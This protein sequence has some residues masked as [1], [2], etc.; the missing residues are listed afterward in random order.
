MIDI[1]HLI[2]HEEL[3]IRELEKR[4]LDTSLASKAAQQYA[5]VN[6]L[7]R[8]LDDVRQ[9]KNEF[10]K[11]VVTLSGEEKQQAISSMKQTSSALKSLEANLRDASSTL[12]NIIYQLPN[13]TWDGIPVAKD[14]AGNVETKVFLERPRFDFEVKHYYELPAFVRDYK[15][16]EGVNAVGARGYYI[17]GQLG[18]LQRALFRWVEDRLISKGF[19]YVTPPVM[20]N[21]E[22]M[23]G[24][25][26]FPSSKNDFYT[27]NPEED[28]LYLVG[29]SEPSLMFLHQGQK[30]DLDQPKMLM[31]NTTCFRREAGTYGKDTKGGIRVHQ[32]EKIEMVSICKPEQSGD[33]F[34]KLTTIFTEILQDLG[35]HFHYLE[36]ST[37]DMSLKNHR[38]I[39]IEAWF[40]AQDK[41]REVCSSSNCTDYQTRNLNIKYQ[42]DD[43]AYKLAH[44]LNCTGITNRTLFAIL[45]Q[46]QHADG[47]VVLP[48]VLRPYTGFD[49][50]V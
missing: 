50:L 17:T 26:F 18:L 49:V 3:Y 2:A 36:V 47:S 16:K 31:A 25:G 19:E 20:V 46:F 38:M 48:E 28:N 43:G 33:V 8:E 10:N 21:E 41:F 12:Q 14:D 9:K 11:K 1:K 13:L 40:P 6:Q 5:H 37:G 29:S 15:A 22:V 24:T 42:K 27:V 23:Y 44:S 39:D 32:F 30:L 7:K 45:E 35:L 34:D 4:F